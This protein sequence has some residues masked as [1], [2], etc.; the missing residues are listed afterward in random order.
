MIYNKQELIEQGYDFEH[1][2]NFK[3]EIGTTIQDDKRHLKI[4]DKCIRYYNNG[5]Q[6]F[7]YKYYIYQCLVCGFIKPISESNLLGQ[8]DG[9]SCCTNQ[10]IVPGINDIATLEPWMISF[11][12][13]GRKEA[14]KYSVHSGKK[15]YMK[16]PYCNRLSRKK[17]VIANMYTKRGFECS[18]RDGVSYPNKFMFSLLEQLREDFIP[19]YSPEWI[20]RKYF[21]FYLPKRNIIIEMDGGLGHGNITWG[22]T[23]DVK[24]FFNDMEKDQ[25]AEIRGIKVIRVDCK[26]SKQSY[27]E[28]N[29]R[30]SELADILDLNK[31]DFN[32]CDRDGNKNIVFEICKYFKENDC[33]FIED[34]K[35]KYPYINH[36]VLG[37]Y[38]RKGAKYGWCDYNG[39]KSR[40]P[41]AYRKICKYTKDG[42][43]IETYDNTKILKQNCNYNESQIGKIIMVC[44]G[45]RQSANGYIWKFS[46]TE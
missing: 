10:I 6:V 18:C 44:K 7:H 14:Q 4:I 23:P 31:V 21:D 16:C 24:G 2:A 27:I 19:E 46:E 42:Q 39:R 29:I 37:E 17:I 30:N 3:L 9:C 25:I 28:E 45:Q 22:N 20:G 35:K 26:K 41:N 43:Y 38:L 34:V 32:I 8:K 40:Y 15:V 12:P 11:F 33:K 5:K 13:G 36:S 1:P